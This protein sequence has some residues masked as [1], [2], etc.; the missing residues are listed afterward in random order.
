LVSISYWNDGDKVRVGWMHDC[1]NFNYNLGFVC[2]WLQLLMTCKFFP[3]FLLTML[4]V[5]NTLCY[6]GQG[7]WDQV[8]IPY[9]MFNVRD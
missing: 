9:K 1:W 7:P 3:L 6:N 2:F 8:Q 4:N 5:I